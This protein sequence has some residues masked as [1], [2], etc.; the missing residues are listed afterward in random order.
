MGSPLVSGRHQPGARRLT[1][2]DERTLR[3]DR[4]QKVSERSLTGYR[5]LAAIWRI[6]NAGNGENALS[7]GFLSG[8]LRI[9]GVLG[10][11]DPPVTQTRFG[12]DEARSSGIVVQ[13]ATELEDHEAESLVATRRSVVPGRRE[14]LLVVQQ[15]SSV[16]D[17]S[18]E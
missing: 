4:V 13:L 12:E 17:E 8:L 18:L 2:P 11:G 16:G 5:N 10:I 1:S 3:T 6:Y 14:Q 9:F 7:D 15:P